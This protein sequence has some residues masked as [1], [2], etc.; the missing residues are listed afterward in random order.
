MRDTEPAQGSSRDIPLPFGSQGASLRGQLATIGS[1]ND[2]RAIVDMTFNNGETSEEFGINDLTFV[3]TP[4]LP[5]TFSSGAPLSAALT[6]G[7]RL[8]G[9]RYDSRDAVKEIER[10]EEKRTKL[11]D[12]N[13]NMIV[14]RYD[15][16]FPGKFFASAANLADT[17]FVDGF[18]AKGITFLPLTDVTLEADSR[19]I[20]I[21]EA[22]E[23]PPVAG[24]TTMTVRGLLWCGDG[25]SGNTTDEICDDRN[26]TNND[27]CTACQI[28]PGYVCTNA[29][30]DPS[31][32]VRQCGNGT[33]QYQQYGETCDDGGIVPGDGCSATCLI[34]NGFRCSGQPVSTCTPAP[35]CGDSTCET[36]ERY[37]ERQCQPWEQGTMCANTDY[38]PNDCPTCGN[39]S[40][41]GNEACDDSNTTPNDGCTSCTVDTD[42]TCNGTAPSICQLCGNG[43]KEG[44]EACDDDDLDPGDGCSATCTVEPTWTCNVASPTVCQNCGNGKKEGTEACDDHDLDPGD[45]CSATCTVESIWTC[46]GT[47]PSICQLCG[48]GKKEGTEAC[49]DSNTTANDG[50]TACVIDTDYACNGTEP[51]ICQLCGNGKKEGTEACDDDDLDPGDGCSAT[52]T[53]EPTWSCNAASLTVCQKCGDNVQQDYGFDG[54]PGIATIDDNSDGVIDNADEWLAED[55]DDEECDAGVDNGAS[56]CSTTCRLTVPLPIGR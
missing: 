23:I 47:E 30:T 5:E 4:E 16:L 52:C 13:G 48:N 34:E 25:I 45:G 41:E 21:A 33:V 11:V 9:Y 39:G 36:R 10:E 27:G 26:R 12:T 29:G 18:A 20:I 35:T 46:N 50:C 2:N 22:G 32:C 37:N 54:L 43:K 24:D 7:K 38:C 15:Y 17:A 3:V 44:T 55:S 31:S 19:Y 42:Y 6:A 14:Y 1:T 51:S 40:K 56:T 28:D 49:D 53:V 8:Y